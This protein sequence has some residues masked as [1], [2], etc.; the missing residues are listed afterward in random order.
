MQKVPAGEREGEKEGGE[1]QREVRKVI[2]MPLS[3]VPEKSWCKQWGSAQGKMF[4]WSALVWRLRGERAECHQS[5]EY[6]SAAEQS[7]MEK[8]QQEHFF[9]M[10][11]PLG[12]R[13]LC[14]TIDFSET[15]LAKYRV[16]NFV[17]TFWGGEKKLEFFVSF[18]FFSD[19]LYIILQYTW[20]ILA[21]LKCTFEL[22]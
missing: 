9:I 21:L 18:W 10:S 16:N 1:K 8:L 7:C 20:H 12:I 3:K 19:R 22:M 14:G 4:V 15:A 13:M 6:W 17:L 5:L 2:G 11:T